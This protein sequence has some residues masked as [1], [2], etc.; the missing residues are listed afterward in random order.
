MP[1]WLTVLIFAATTVL[2]ELL[3]PKVSQERD[4]PAG[5]GDFKFPT[6]TEGRPVPLLWGTAVVDG[7]NVIWYGDLE[8]QTDKKEVST[9]LFSS[10]EIITGYRYFVGMHFAICRGQATLKDILIE[11]KSQGTTLPVYYAWY[12]SI[13][14]EKLIGA[15]YQ[16]YLSGDGT[17]T[18]NSY[19]SGQL[20]PAVVPGYRDIAQF[21]FEGFVGTSPNVPK[22]AFKVERI[23]DPLNMAVEDPGAQRIDTTEANPVNVLYEILTDTDWG[24]GIPTAEIDITN[25]RTAAST[26]ADEGNGFSLLLDQENEA[27]KIITEL[28]R[29]IDASLYYDRSD[30][31]WK[32]ILI[33]DDYTPAS[34]P[35]YDES[36]TVELVEYAKT[37]WTN[38]ANQARLRFFDKSDDYKETF[39]FAQDLAN[40]E[41]Q[42]ANVS[43]EVSYPGVKM[44]TLANKLVW[45]E[46]GTSSYP[47][48]KHTMKVNRSGF[49]LVPGSVY[50]WS[51]GALGI[52]EKVMRVTKLDYG[53][54]NSGLV[55]VYSVEDIFTTPNTGVFGDPSNTDWTD[56]DVAPVAATT[57][58][59]LEA[60]L[61]FVFRDAYDPTQTKR[62]WYGVVKPSG[63]TVEAD[64]WTAFNTVASQPA[65][66]SFSYDSTPTRFVKRGTLNAALDAYGS[67]IIQLWNGTITLDDLDDLS[68]SG[69]TYG[70]VDSLKGIAAIGS[71]NDIEYIIYEIA[72][73]GTNQLVLDNVYRGVFHTTSRD[74]PSGTTVTL[75]SQGGALLK[76]FIAENQDHAYVKPISRS[77]S[78]ATELSDYQPADYYNFTSVDDLQYVPSAAQHPYLHG[79]HADDTNVS[80]DTKYG[81]V[82]IS[83]SNEA[84]AAIKLEV[85]ARDWKADN[86]GI[87]YNG[88]SD[89]V[90]YAL[91]KADDPLYDVDFILIK[92]GPTEVTV[93]RNAWTEDITMEDPY[94]PS[95]DRIVAYIKRTEMIK[96]LGPNTAI[97][98]N[99]RIEVIS[100]HTPDTTEYVCP[101]KLVH[102]LTITSSLQSA[103]LI[104]GGIPVNTDSTTIQFN[105]T[106]NYSFQTSHV[107][108]S[109]GVLQADKNGGGFNT[110]ISTGQASGTLAVTSGDDVTL[111]FTVA[112]S[113]DI[114]LDITGPTA[115]F[116][117]AVLE[118]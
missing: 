105:E 43:S 36:N 90:S 69:L 72:T 88:I 77:R 42:G 58:V 73:V 118:A 40:T 108:P 30:G 18:A 65:D 5:L 14:A 55:T 86:L 13:L 50:R 100:K 51:W 26:V 38:T 74:W 66:G 111:K 81:L 94:N 107:M 48:A 76:S 54:L 61:K 1:W 68:E 4:R 57:T 19:L 116:G 45:R 49:D 2:A 91:W 25:F 16:Q 47:L 44:R 103:D 29:Q 97:P 84:G 20:S 46:L 114:H 110:V 60:P 113:Y 35:L 62:L 32:L 8:V 27:D 96:I 80:V 56:P 109:G 24:L 85:E 37:S 71:G 67:S 12:G 75:L 99:A 112:E 78:Q 102:D 115:E 89:S 6:A 28:L 7:P 98:S 53:T 92:P 34:L 31:L 106:G 82:D 117:Y 64:A 41:I 87:D 22:F 59:L 70:S 104:F 63:G 93:A 101:Q 83:F 21:I 10:T 17:H 11:K 39:A 9:G 23:P 79:T 33:R 95:N 15:R 3:R 52:S